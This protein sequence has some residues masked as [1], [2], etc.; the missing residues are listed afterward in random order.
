[1]KFSGKELFELGVPQNKIKFFV[2]R[3]FDSVEALKAELAPKEVKHEERVFT[4]VDWIMRTFPVT[5]LPMG[6]KGE[7][8]VPMS[9]SELKRIFDSKSIQINGY[10]PNSKDECRDSDFPIWEFVWFPKGKRKTT[11]R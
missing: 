2:G 3:E 9:R 6:L 5:W 4:W 11:W 10:F 7:L 8:P 1:M